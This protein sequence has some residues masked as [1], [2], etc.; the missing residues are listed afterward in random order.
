MSDKVTQRIGMG[1]RVAVAEVFDEMGE[2]LFHSAIGI[3]L[4]VEYAAHACEKLFVNLMDLVRQQRP[5]DSGIRKLLF[6]ALHAEIEH[7][8][9]ERRQARKPVAQNIL[10]PVNNALPQMCL[11]KTETM[12]HKLREPEREILLFKALGGLSL[13]DYADITGERFDLV[14]RLHRDAVKKAVEA[15]QVPEGEPD[16]PELWLKRVKFRA[17]AAGLR[18]RA[19]QAFI[20]HRIGTAK[21]GRRTIWVAVALFVLAGLGVA[22]KV[23]SDLQSVSIKEFFTGP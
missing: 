5:K 11:E 18:N 16:D 22:L 17:P 23:L 10:M 19:I 3:T 2:A 9:K 20:T 7:S 13:A 15:L 12:L 4:D 6:H 8:L 14:D 1:D 21:V